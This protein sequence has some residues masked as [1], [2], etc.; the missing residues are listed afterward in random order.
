MFFK[1]FILSMHEMYGMVCERKVMGLKRIQ[2]LS[3]AEKEMGSCMSLNVRNY[4]TAN[5]LL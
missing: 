1:K 3:E 2:I 4:T 5:S